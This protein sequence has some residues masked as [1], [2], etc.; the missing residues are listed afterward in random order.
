MLQKFRGSLGHYF[1]VIFRETKHHA[2]AIHYILRACNTGPFL[3][4]LA[5]RTRQTA[6]KCMFMAGVESHSPVL[7]RLLLRV[8]WCSCR[9]RIPSYIGSL[10]GDSK[11]DLKLRCEGWVKFRLFKV[12]H[13]VFSIFDGC[14]LHISAIQPLKSAPEL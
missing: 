8:T 2:Q 6:R 5:Q 7:Q 4:Q 10:Y 9:N 12:A 11:T 14:G 1:C 13:G 3:W